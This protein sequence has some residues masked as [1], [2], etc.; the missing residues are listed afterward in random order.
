MRAPAHRCLSLQTLP[1]P[2]PFQ[3]SLMR[4]LGLRGLQFGS[5]DRLYPSC[6]SIDLCG[7]V[8]SAGLTT[9]PGR[10]SLIDGRAL[11]LQQD[12]VRP[13]PFADG[14]F[15]WAYAEH[16]IEHIPLGDAVRW[17][18]EVRRVLR[19]GGLVRITTPDLRR[20][21]EGYLDPDGAFFAEHRRRLRDAALPVE[22]RPAWMVNQIF[23][24]WGHQWVYDLEEL[25]FVAGAAGFA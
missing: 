2:P 18:K 5:K 20:Y 10:I 12:A 17:L 9:L 13:L 15:E 21:V 1:A 19:P 7:F 3:P 22:T 8:D 16:F 14:C 4:E 11:F 25:R 23:R 24:F 6:L